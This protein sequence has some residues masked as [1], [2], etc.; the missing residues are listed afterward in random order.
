M[1]SDVLNRDGS[2]R[3]YL[4]H[5]LAGPKGEVEYIEI[6]A[7]LLPRDPVGRGEHPLDARPPL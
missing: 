2:W 1:P 3:V 6:T 5:P 7:Q 4:N